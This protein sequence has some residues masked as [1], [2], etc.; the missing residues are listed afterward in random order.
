MLASIIFV[1]G[2]SLMTPRCRK[3]ASAG[4]FPITPNV[5]LLSP[6]GTAGCRCLGKGQAALRSKR[7]ST[8]IGLAIRWLALADNH[9]VHHVGT[10]RI[11][12]QGPAFAPPFY[13]RLR[14]QNRVSGISRGTRRIANRK[15]SCLV[16]APLALNQRPSRL[17][18]HQ[19][20]CAIHT[21][22]NHV[23]EWSAAP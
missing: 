1:C 19:L 5:I 2:L 22:P 21:P 6:L 16:S 13:I 7:P 20:C 11:C 14:T 15:G 18:F 10:C 17:H 9:R 12:D 3:T 8:L 4:T 23:G